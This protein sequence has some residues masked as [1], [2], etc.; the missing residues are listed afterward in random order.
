MQTNKIIFVSLFLSF[1]IGCKKEVDAKKTSISDTSKTESTSRIQ[2]KVNYLSNIDNKSF[3]VSC[4]GGCA[5]TYT[6]EDIKKNN[7]SFL[8]KFKV[9]MYVDEQLSDT[10]N[11]T[12]LFSYDESNTIKKIQLDGK[13]ENALETLPSGA[14]KSFIEFSQTLINSLSGQQISKTESQLIPESNPK[15]IKL[16]FS[17]YQYFND[18]FSETFYPGYE[19]TP[20][21]KDFLKSKDYEGE[22]YKSFVI[23]ADE[24][25]LY[26]IVSVARGDSEYFVL[27][28]SKNNSIID[29]KEIGAIGGEDPVTFKV[30]PNFTIEKYNGN[31]EKLTAFEKL[32][33]NES[34]KIVKE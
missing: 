34:G 23:R 13:N 21:L 4:G 1:S 15:K 16:P 25:W 8:V 29:Y 28:T 3:V 5:M 18:N 10:Y 12:Y 17:F 6:A 32:K 30:F 27:I 33:I 11:E 19:A 20:F 14:K 9:E 2:D 26:I 22:T 24:N 31:G 7:S